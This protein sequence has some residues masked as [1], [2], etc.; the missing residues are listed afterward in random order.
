M[1]KKRKLVSK[2]IKVL[3][4]INLLYRRRY[5]V[6][7]QKV[8][9]WEKQKIYLEG[10]LKSRTRHV[11]FSTTDAPRVHGISP[12]LEKLPGDQF[13]SQLPLVAMELISLTAPN[14]GSLIDPSHFCLL[15]L[16]IK[17]EKS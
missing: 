9:R 8:Y 3:K 17:L 1:V 10:A 16:C 14:T 13:L 7:W 4:Q 15:H 5:K 11:R 6:L 12:T 2:C